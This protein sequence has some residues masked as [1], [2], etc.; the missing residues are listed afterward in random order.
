MARL[1][2]YGLTPQWSSNLSLGL[3][4]TVST[5]GIA[6]KEKPCLLLWILIKYP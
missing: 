3:G 1:L 4:T 6:G 2:F 5:M